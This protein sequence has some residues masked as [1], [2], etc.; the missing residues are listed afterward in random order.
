MENGQHDEAVNLGLPYFHLFFIDFS[1]VS[2]EK[3]GRSNSTRWQTYVAITNI[4]NGSLKWFFLGNQ[5]ASNNA[6]FS[7]VS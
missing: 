7:R 1:L 3:M 4:P 6:G 5:R 2:F